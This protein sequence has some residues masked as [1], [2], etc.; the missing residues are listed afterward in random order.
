MHTHA[1]THMCRLHD[2]VNDL[3]QHRMYLIFE[4]LDGDLYR[5]MQVRC[6][7]HIDV[8]PSELLF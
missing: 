4:Y 8:S 5:L 2:V 7:F 1:H 3:K 6:C